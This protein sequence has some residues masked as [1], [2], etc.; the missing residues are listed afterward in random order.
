MG[1]GRL[2]RGV[3]VAVVRA[4][5]DLPILTGVAGSGVVA[6][7]L[8]FTGKVRR[9]ERKGEAW[10]TVYGLG[11]GDYVVVLYEVGGR[12]IGATVYACPPQEEKQ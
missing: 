10:V 7:V 2:L 3:E 8:D 5:G 6:R 4:C 12:P 1:L 11:P 9:V